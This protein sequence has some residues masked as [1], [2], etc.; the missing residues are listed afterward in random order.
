MPHNDDYDGP[1]RG[2]VYAIP[3]ALTMWAVIILTIA[4]LLL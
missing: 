1:V 2:A 4:L 3:A